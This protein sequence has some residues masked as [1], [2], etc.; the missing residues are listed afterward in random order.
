[1]LCTCTYLAT[2]G[3]KGLNTSKQPDGWTDG[4]LGLQGAPK[5]VTP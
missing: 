3:I 2:V 4:W 5:K 1:M